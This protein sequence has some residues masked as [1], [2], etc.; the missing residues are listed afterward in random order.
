MYNRKKHVEHA[1][2]LIL[3]QN[4]VNESKLIMKIILKILLSSIT[5]FKVEHFLFLLKSDGQSSH[6]YA[7]SKYYHS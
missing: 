2:A 6:E 4:L 1:F 3:K 5:Q 7:F